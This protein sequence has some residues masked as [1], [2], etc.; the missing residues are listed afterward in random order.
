MRWNFAFSPEFS[1]RR[2]IFGRLQGVTADYRKHCGKVAAK[3]DCQWH[4]IKFEE[5]KPAPAVRPAA[6]KSVAPPTQKPAVKSNEP[7]E[8]A[9]AAVVKAKE[10]GI[11]DGTR[12]DDPVTHEEAIVLTM[13]A[14]GLATRT[15]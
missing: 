5:E 10:L 8:W 12:L 6:P 13:R 11:S 1:R 15:K 9:K 2:R 7:S 4:D 14:A 3:V